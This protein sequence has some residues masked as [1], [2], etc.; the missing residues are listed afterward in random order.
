LPG[1]NDSPVRL[2]GYILAFL[3]GCASVPRAQMELLHPRILLTTVHFTIDPSQNVHSISRYIYGVNQSLTGPYSNLTLERAG[4]NRWTAYNWENNASNAGSDYLF[5]NDDALGGG[6]TP[7]GAVIP[8]LNDAASH[9]AAA[10]ITVPMNG[11]VAADKNGGGNV[12]F[13]NNM[14]DP[15]HETWVNG[16]PNPNYL[17]QRFK[18]ELPRKGSAFTLTPNP[19]DQYVY[20]DEFVN[21]VKTEYPAS[22]TNP[23]TPI[24][25]DL[26]NEP[27]IWSSTHAEVHPNPIT[28]DELKMDTINYASAIKDVDPAALVFGPV[29]YGWGGMVNLQGATDANG[30]DFETYYLQQMAAAQQTYGKRLVDALDVHWYPEATGTNGIRITADDSSAATVAARLQAPRSLWDPTYTESSWITQYSTL[31]PIDLIPRLQGK[32][33]ANYPGTKLAISEYNYGGWDDISGGIAE[34]D[35]LGIFGVQNVFEASEWPGT[36]NGEPF[37]SGA[38]QMYRNYDGANSTFGDT[39]ISATTDDV[40]HSSVYASLDSTHPGVLTIIAINKTSSSLDAAINLKGVLPQG[41][42]SVYKLTSAS[43]TPQSAGTFAITDPSNMIYTM[44]PMSVNTIRIQIAAPTVVPASATYQY[45]TSPNKISFKFNQDVAAS[46]PTDGMTITRT[47]GSSVPATFVSYDSNNIATFSIATPLTDGNY[48]LTI[49]N[50]GITNRAFQSMSAN[51]TFNFFSLTGDANHD[52]VVNLL[53][54]NAL[55]TNFG[56]SNKTFT[57]GDFNY[58]GNV[59]VQDFNALATRFGESASQLLASSLPLATLSIT[60]APQTAPAAPTL[61]DGV[62]FDPTRHDDNGPEQVL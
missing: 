61:L 57:D 43:S 35:V 7:G 4:G 28:Y 22:Q 54:L 38:F 20:E 27:D 60:S 25:F 23:N 50:A 14:W 18:Q 10:L 55:A 36:S 16:T 47:G 11:Y 58:S 5:Q 33:D 53:D 41:S 1:G 62:L 44:L 51:F 34:A 6:D 48:T 17:L 49:P 3:N 56:K 15:V 21:W 42:A 59:D 24:F 26:D 40:P 13:N 19:S 37:I 9:N 32:I 8:T 29:N 39:S 12:E 45:Q 31:G 46:L 30:R 2:T 52:G